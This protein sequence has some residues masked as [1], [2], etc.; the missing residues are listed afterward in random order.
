MGTRS[1]CFSLSAV[2]AVLL[3]VGCDEVEERLTW[4]PD[5]SRAIMRVGDKLCLLDTN[6]NL[7]VPLASNVV[8]AAWLPDSQGLVLLRS[9]KVADWADAVRL[10]PREE[11][12]TVESLAKGLPDL[13]KAGL[14]LAD[15]DETNMQKRFFD[16]LKMEHPELL[17]PAILCM[18]DTRAAALDRA[19]Q[20]AKDP[21][22]LKEDLTNSRTTGVAEV[23]VL[24][25]KGDQPANPPRVIE[26]TLTDL[27]QPRPSPSAGAVAFMRGEALMV[28]P[29][30]GG[31]NRVRVA[32]R[33]EG[34]YD[35][36]PDGKALV[37]AVR[38]AEKWEDGAINLVRIER[39]TVIGPNGELSAGDAQALAIGCSSF[40]PRVRCLPDGRVLFAAV[41]QRLPAPAMAEQEARFYLIDPALGSNAVPVAVPSAPGA[42]PQD[43]AA[44]APSPDG[45]QIAIVEGGSDSVAVLDVATGALE[46]VSPKRGWKSRILP[47]WRGTD[48]LYFAALPES[49]STRPEL[50]RWRK[51]SAPQVFSRSWTGEAVGGLLEKPE[52]VTRDK[53]RRKTG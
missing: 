16:E 28:A 47:A 25:L 13:L 30:D 40:K 36:T 18:L 8:S 3:A 23:S 12:A 26:R 15:G 44:F 22:K 48:E 14:E 17:S 24:L 37:Y 49:S 27:Q 2:A 52:Q 50:L 33:V 29:L 38:F 5:G 51:G 10:L 41:Q 7:S 19:I 45:H 20:T 6:G 34:S 46:V 39:R 53:T 9:I 4:A 42:L 32:E 43:L 21:H 1:L 31:T 11:T 35:W